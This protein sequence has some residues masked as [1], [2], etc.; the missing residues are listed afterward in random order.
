MTD[1]E[2]NDWGFYLVV[3]D[4]ECLDIVTGVIV[5]IDQYGSQMLVITL[6]H[7]WPGRAWGGHKAWE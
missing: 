2:A 7:G 3:M 5:N 1:I 4:T 6:L